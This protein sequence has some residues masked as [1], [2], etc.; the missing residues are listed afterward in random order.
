MQ[1]CQE[2]SVVYAL[3]FKAYTYAPSERRLQNLKMQTF[4]EQRSILMRTLEE[5][6]CNQ[7][8]AL[9]LA[10]S[11]VLTL[12]VSGSAMKVSE[13]CTCKLIDCTLARSSQV[14]RISLMNPDVLAWAMTALFQGYPGELV[15]LLES[16]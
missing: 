4:S 8:Q 9:D 13:Q 10:G 15:L 6:S 12:L 7:D 16:L 2:L 11:L 5:Q 1:T 14:I 3:I